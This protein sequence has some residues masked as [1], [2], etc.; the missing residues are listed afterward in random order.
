MTSLALFL[1]RAYQVGL[2]P[3]LGG[4]CRFTPSCSDYALEA[5]REFGAARGSWLAL[6]RVARCHPWG[7]AGYDPVPSSS[8]DR[9]LE[10]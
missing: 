6:T 2:S 1:V 9:G 3:L 7:G 10:R 4:Q 8:A 5:I